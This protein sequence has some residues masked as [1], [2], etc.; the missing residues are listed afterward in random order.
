MSRSL[1]HVFDCAAGAHSNEMDRQVNGMAITKRCQLAERR[2]VSPS[3][4][5]DCW[6]ADGGVAEPPPLF[7][8]N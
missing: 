1:A 5:V 3:L 8:V 6:R 7:L 4:G 2:P